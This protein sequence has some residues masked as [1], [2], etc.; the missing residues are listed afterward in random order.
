[1]K[2]KLILISMGPA[3]TIFQSSG[4]LAFGGTVLC[5]YSEF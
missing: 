1:M 3:S 2:E 5:L 4:K